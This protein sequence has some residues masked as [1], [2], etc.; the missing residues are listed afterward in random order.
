MTR[1]RLTRGHLRS[2]KVFFR[3]CSAIRGH[4]HSGISL[5]IL[6]IVIGYFAV[7]SYERYYRFGKI[8]IDLNLEYQAQ[9]IVGQP[10]TFGTQVKFQ[11]VRFLARKG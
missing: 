5:N 1:H 3:F 7:G 4:D 10:R 6:R 9:I 8:K 11:S 2:L